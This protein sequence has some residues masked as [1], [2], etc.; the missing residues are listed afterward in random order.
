MLSISSTRRE[1]IIEVLVELPAMEPPEFKSS[2]WHRY[3]H[4]SRFIPRFNGA[5]FSVVGDVPVD[6]DTPVVTL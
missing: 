6:N 5:I 2:T 1:L 4:F 3:L